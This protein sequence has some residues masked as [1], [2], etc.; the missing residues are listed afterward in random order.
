MRRS[1]RSGVEDLW[2]KTVRDADGNTQSVPSARDGRGMRWRARYVD[3]RGGEHS[4]AFGRKVDA[5]LWLDKQTAALVSAFAV[6]APRD[7]QLTVQQWCDLWI[8]GYKVNRES[9]VRQAPTHCVPR[10]RVSAA[11][12][13]QRV[14]RLTRRSRAR[15]RMGSPGG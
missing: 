8:E 13:G 5:Q 15:T 3:E 4:K 2:T 14:S 6:V 10:H 11:A 12:A 7:A 1:R 9:T